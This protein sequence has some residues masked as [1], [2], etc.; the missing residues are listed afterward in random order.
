MT[1]AYP[2]MLVGAGT[3]LNTE[4]VDARN[5]SRGEIHRK[6]WI[7]SGHSRVLREERD[8]NSSD[9]PVQVILNRQ[10]NMV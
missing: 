2:E 8:S 3:V 5:R 10:S 4:Q 7:E 9:A 1:K 6:P